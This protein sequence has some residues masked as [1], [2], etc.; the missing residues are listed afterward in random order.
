LKERAKEVVLE[1]AGVKPPWWRRI[2]HWIR[3]IP[4]WI[5]AGMSFLTNAVRLVLE[6]FRHG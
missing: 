3:R 1:E 6:L 5:L 4:S 2:V